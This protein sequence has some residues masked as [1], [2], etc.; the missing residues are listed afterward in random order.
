MSS[1]S[2]IFTAPDAKLGEMLTVK[3]A[4]VSQSYGNQELYTPI[5][6]YLC[7]FPPRNRKRYLAAMY[8]QYG[9]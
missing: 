1:S 6:P 7:F 2:R 3:Q 9:S 5:S 4:K 8:Q